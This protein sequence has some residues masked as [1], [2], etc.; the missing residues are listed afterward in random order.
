MEHKKIKYILTDIEGTTTSVSFVYDILF[1]YFK[2]HIKEI[3]NFSQLQEVKEAF[4]QVIEIVADEENEQI[5]TSEE[6]LKYL[7]KWSNEDRKVTPLKTIQGILWR[8][9]YNSGELKGHVYDDV[10][11]A[12][13]DWKNKGL[14]L[15]VFSSGSIAAQKL[16]FGN[17][18]FGDLSENFLHY[19]DTNTGQKQDVNTYIEIAKKINLLPSKILFLSDI[20]QEL[21]AA[22]EA[23]FQTLQLVRLGTEISWSNY[24]SDFSEINSKI[25]L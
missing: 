4:S 11:L 16:I 15:G 19:F 25:G 7:E 21:E 17:S 3:N 23:G 24:V 2:A 5:T 6:V 8:N 18:I 20:Q 13:E 10:P 1:P 14:K 9:G 22:N 12:L